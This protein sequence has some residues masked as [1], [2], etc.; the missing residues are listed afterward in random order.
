MTVV[1]D[2][3][4]AEQAHFDAAWVARESTRKTLDGAGEAAGGPK[5]AAAAVRRAAQAA[6]SKLGAPE[7]AVAVGRIDI[8]GETLYVGKHAISDDDHDL[9]VINWQAPAAIPYFEAS[10]DNAMGVT[11][12]RTFTCTRN[13]I[14]DFDDIL[15]EELAQRVAGMI[16]TDEERW[17]VDD[18][19]LR[20]LDAGRTGEM[21]DIVQTI[22]AAQYAL[23]RSPLEQL[24]IIQGGPGTGKTAVALHR[25]SWL[26]FNHAGALPPEDV[27]VV[28]PTD[29][30]TKYIRGVLP[31][32]GDDNVEYRD[33]R[34]L[35]PQ[36]STGRH[37]STSV[38]RI[39]GEARMV[40]L[41]RTALWQRVR[42]PERAATIEVGTGFG[43]PRFT[44]EEIESELPRHRDRGSYNVGRASF[45]S[46]I[47]RETSMRSPRGVVIAPATVDAAVERVWPSLTTT[48]F[49]RD[50][51]GSRDRLLAAAGDLFTASEVS[52]LSRAASD[53]VSDE[54]WSDADVALLDE[55]DELINGRFT[56][57]YGHIVV[58]EAQDLSPMQL[59]SIRRRSSDGS[60]TV[61]GDIA[62]S[63]GPWARN[64]WDD[65]QAAL[66][67]DAKV[68]FEQLE[69]GYRVPRQIYEFAAQLLP[70]VAPGLTPPTV[71]R[72]GPGE[73]ELVMSEDGDLV[74]AALSAARGHAG[75]GRFV[76]VICPDAHRQK[77]ED[78]LIWHDVKWADVGAGQLD[79]SINIASPAEAK[80]LEF[81][82][83]VILDPAAIVHES[84]W[85]LRHLYVA[86]TRTTK[87]LT[88]VHTGDP[89]PLPKD[90][91]V[92]DGL[93]EIAEVRGLEQTDLFTP[94]ARESTPSAQIVSPQPESDD[95]G[96]DPATIDDH[97]A[98][99]VARPRHS[100]R[101]PRL[102]LLNRTIVDGA[103]ETIAAEIR[104]ALAPDL[105]PAVIERLQELMARTANDEDDRR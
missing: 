92:S 16:A 53:K 64:S 90:Q 73:P 11:L 15:F 77:L 103:A 100:L 26:L 5:K 52:R 54:Q 61:L 37:E 21:R 56:A 81:D 10:F 14:E 65:V 93:L 84:E 91:T 105:W 2:V 55:A 79:A 62:Q 36:R 97:A 76:G 58:D 38:R 41:L 82:A 71:V 28:G 49:L 85:G 74:D 83:V 48:A 50:L 60:M 27:L 20:D 7:E 59:R 35:G 34:S 18:A 19:L 40:D 22:Q 57:T 32:L 95:L 51:F 47:Q 68:A 33:L 66:T 23:V 87:Y 72:L 9:L 80:G 39:K 88:V 25:V 13:E 104:H 43:S 63:T 89:L 101:L 24:L 46:F 17:G 30:F 86:L 67:M 69:L 94:T 44:R 75:S 78:E 70:Y 29:T 4:K 45:R 6:I 98:A 42:F 96:A 102:G 8:A 1:Q 3:L 12:K 31:G 99:G